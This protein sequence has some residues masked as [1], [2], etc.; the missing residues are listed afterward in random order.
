MDFARS[1]G[2]PWCPLLVLT[3]L[4]HGGHKTGGHFYPSPHFRIEKIKNNPTYI[5]VLIL[6]W[7]P[8]VLV[9]KTIATKTLLSQQDQRHSRLEKTG[10]FTREQCETDPATQS[11]SGCMEIVRTNLGYRAVQSSNGMGHSYPSRYSALIG[12]DFGFGCCHNNT[13]GKW[14]VPIWGHF[15]P[16]AVSW[17]NKRAGAAIWI[18]DHCSPEDP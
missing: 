6:A 13:T 10:V 9:N 12:F 18:W 8:R 16:S 3:K 1:P 15:V 14:N 4:L 17:W 11:L 5:V 7:F 2:L